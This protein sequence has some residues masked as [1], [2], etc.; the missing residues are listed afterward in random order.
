MLPEVRTSDAVAG[1]PWGLVI[2]G[3]STGAIDGRTADVFDPATERRIAIV[4]EAGSADVALAVG[5]A[6]TA[7]EDWR[8]ISP[9]VRAVMVRRLAAL[10]RERT[11][12]FAFLDALDAGLPISFMR[13]DVARGADMLELFA[14]W[15]LELGGQT[16]PATAD[17]LH[18]TVREPFGVVG[19]IVPF[20]HPFM[21]AAGKIA[22]PLVA[23]NTVVL[24]PAV[25]TPLSALRLGELAAEI[26]PP[27]VLNVV[28]GERAGHDLVAH[29]E[30]RRL[31]FIG[32]DTV[33]RAIQRAAAESGVKTVTL[34]LGGKN[35]MIVLPDAD[36]DRAAAGA[37]AGM[38]FVGVAGQ[39]C[40]SNSRL[41]VHPDIAADLV[42]RITHRMEQL[43]IGSPLDDR[44]QVGPLISEAQRTRTEDFVATALADG[45]TLRAGGRRP[46]GIDRGHFYL[47]TMFTGV[48]PGSRLG[49]E[50]V[51]GPVM[52]VMQ[53]TD[54]DAAIRMANAVRFGLTASVWTNDLRSAHHAVR[55]LDAGFVWINGS[56]QHFFGVPFGGNKLSGVGRE[57]GVEE[58]LS[59][60]QTKAVNVML[61]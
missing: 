20:N 4:P 51:F 49:Q 2:D 35:A 29:P 21:F 7:F 38:N 3:R 17:N 11:E 5:T 41:I 12:E 43:V 32:S 15:A 37:V 47:P 23:G 50:E 13:D 57:E 39:S 8:R 22:A 56:G 26:L 24:K 45:A 52:S 53:A 16:I 33:G 55:E 14:D 61:G 25:Q 18:Y 28:T 31:A 46:D 36:L 9:R 27:G 42:E 19:R 59:F 40:G 1:H 30:V 10:I 54:L 34:E 48:G 58:L 6:A 60:T 44:T